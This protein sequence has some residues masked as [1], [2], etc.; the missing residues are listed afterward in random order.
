MFVACCH[1]YTISG[2]Y[3]VKTCRI[4]FFRRTHFYRGNTKTGMI[5]K[6]IISCITLLFWVDSTIFFYVK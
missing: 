1:A 4:A 6:A 2:T 5:S 3:K